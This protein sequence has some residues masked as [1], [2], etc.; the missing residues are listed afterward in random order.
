MARQRE[1]EIADVDKSGVLR[2]C[3]PQTNAA[4]MPREQKSSQIPTMIL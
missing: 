4:K 3:Y 1:R 2:P